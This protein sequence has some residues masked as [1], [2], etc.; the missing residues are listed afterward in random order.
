MQTLDK[1]IKSIPEI[2]PGENLQGNKARVGGDKRA[3]INSFLSALTGW[4]SPETWF[5]W[6]FKIAEAGSYA[7]EIDQATLREDPSEFVVYL[8]GKTFNGQ[9]KTTPSLEKFETIRLEGTVEL[10]AGKIYS[11]V[12]TAGEKIQP[13]MMDIGSVRLVKP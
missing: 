10:A 13:R 1:V 2:K 8:G 3:S 6:S 9:S 12:L 7:I 5:I 11:L 4:V